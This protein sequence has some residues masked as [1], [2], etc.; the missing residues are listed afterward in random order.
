MAKIK[1]RPVTDEQKTAVIYARYS[2]HAQ[3]DASI[4][5]QIEECQAFAARNNLRI[6]QIYA[7]RAI[8]GRTD[9]RPEFQKMMRHAES[10]AFDAIVAYKSNRIA[11]NMLNALSTETKLAQFGVSIMYAREMFGNDAAG[12]YA[13]RNMMSLNQFY[14]ENMAEDIKRGHH[15]NALQCKINGGGM[16]LGYKRGDD[17]RYA[18]DEATAPIVREIFHRVG[19]LEPQAEIARDLEA[20][21]I[22][23]A[24][25]NKW[26]RSSFHCLLKNKKYIGI[27][28]YD[29][30]EIEGGM[31]R[32]V[33]DEEFYRVQDMLARHGGTWRRHGD[34][35]EYMLT[36]KVYCGHCGS[37]MCGHSGTSRHTDIYRYY[38]CTKRYREKLCDKQ[39]VRQDW[40]EDLVANAIRSY[41]LVD[42]VIEWI[43]DEMIAYRDKVAAES[44]LTYLEQQLADTNARIDNIMHAIEQGIFSDTTRERLL[45][46]EAERRKYTDAL[47]RECAAL[48]KY[49]RADIIEYLTSLRTLRKDRKSLRRAMFAQFLSRVDLFDD[50]ILLTFDV[51]G[52]SRG[53]TL[54]AKVEI[55]K[56]ADHA[57]SPLCSTTVDLREIQ[58]G[59][60]IIAGRLIL[61]LKIAKK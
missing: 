26:T 54:P 16:P 9:R 24:A 37:R 33:S 4:E 47:A 42:D 7:D 28:I 8:S 11:R 60:K 59:L 45:S 49:A 18:I 61:I 32:I 14:S 43:A 56:N 48:P 40:L 52:Q 2:S 12:R 13:L 58:E 25:G 39:N 1:N 29:G 57:Q 55:C 44:N 5:Q 27:Y 15:D 23:T 51:N 31:P 17:G 41:V 10:G 3:N 34:A 50:K 35:A 30:I 46:L 36:G 53:I 20:R 38:I 22:K 21:G 6:I 19:N